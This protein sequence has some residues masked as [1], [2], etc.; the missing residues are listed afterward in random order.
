[1]DQLLGR[2]IVVTGASRGVGLECTRLFLAEGAQVIAVARDETRLEA[3]RRALDPEGRALTTVAVD[4]KHED[5]APRVA[6]AVAERFG[7][8]D[9]LFNN[10]GIQ[11]DGAARG[12]TDGSES[13]LRE[14]IEVN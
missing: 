11:I 3:A 2:K 8:L 12:L 6:S 4:L 10:A 5:A 7:A 1:M 14:S 13:V 9:V